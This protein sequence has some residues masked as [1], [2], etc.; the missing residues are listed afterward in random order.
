MPAG[1]EGQGALGTKKIN[2]DNKNIDINSAHD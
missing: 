1:E 2:N